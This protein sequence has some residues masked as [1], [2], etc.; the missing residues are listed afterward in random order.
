[1]N[2]NITYT[3]NAPLD[4]NILNAFM[5]KVWAGHVWTDYNKVLSRSLCYITAYHCNELIGFINI[6]WDGNKHAF[7]LDT[8]VDPNYRNKGIGKTIVNKAIAQCKD[9]SIEWIHVD[10]EVRYE[11]FYKQCGFIQKTTASLLHLT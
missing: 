5:E 11:N 9:F 8:S 7:L 10:Y 6:A 2:Y 3:V 1:M 4:V